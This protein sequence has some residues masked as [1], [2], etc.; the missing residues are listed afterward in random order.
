MRLELAHGFAWLGASQHDGIDVDAVAAVGSWRGTHVDRS[1]DAAGCAEPTEMFVVL[2]QAG[3][4][5]AG[6]V[7]VALDDGVP[8][9]FEML[10]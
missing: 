6:A 5:G 1:G 3:R 7:D 9:V 8:A 2:I 4:E 10:A